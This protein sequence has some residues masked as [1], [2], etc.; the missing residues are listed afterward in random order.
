[1]E[2]RVV[3]YQSHNVVDLLQHLLK[4]AHNSLYTLQK[5]LEAENGGFQLLTDLT[6]QME[7]TRQQ[8][9]SEVRK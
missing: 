2:T 1:M 7:E 9:K 8:L 5:L 4:D 3:L 6:T